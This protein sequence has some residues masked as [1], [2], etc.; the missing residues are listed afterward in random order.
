M[1]HILFFDHPE[2][3][4]QNLTGGKGVNLGRLSQA[5]FHVPPGFSVST[6]AYGEFVGQG[7][8]GRQI[9]ELLKTV[10]YDDPA[11]L[12]KQSAAIRDLLLSAPVPADIAEDIRAAYQMLG[13]GI[14]VAVRSSGTA[15]DL[16][17]ASFAG[18]HDTYLD[19]RGGDEV[20]D[21]VRR[22]WASLWTARAIDYRHHN[23]FEHNAVRIAV[24]VQKMVRSDVAGVMFTANPLTTATDETVIN[25]T[26]GLGES[27]VQG[28]VTPDQYVVQMP[29]NTLIEQMPG[30]KEK[31]MVRDQATGSG[32]LT[33][34]VPEGERARFCLD[35]SQLAEL[36]RL[37]EKVQTYYGGF[38]QD[39]EWAIEDGV[40]Y[41]LQSRPITGVEFS[42]DADVDAAHTQGVAADAVWTRAF[43]DA[44]ASGVVSPLT[45]STR[46]PLFSDRNLRYIW[47]NF[48]CQDLA[49][50]RA[51]KYWK[52]ELYYN[53]EFERRFVERMVPPPLRPMLLDF[54]PPLQHQEMI[55]APFDEAQ[56]LRIIMRWHMLDNQSTPTMATKTFEQWRRRTDYEGLSYAQLRELDDEAVIAYCQRMTEIFGEWND[57]M[58]V[59]IPIT[60]RLLMSGLKWMLS[61]WYDGG[62][63]QTAF[64]KL[65]AG[66]VRRTD[67]QL[68]ND[69]LLALVNIIRRS[70]HLKDALDRHEGEAFF[71]DIADLQEGRDFLRRYDQWIAKW[72]HRG[73]ADRDYMYPRR[74]EDPA[75]DV[76][77]FKVMMNADE[78]HDAEAAEREISH[79]RQAMLDDV[80]ANL[81]LKSGGAKKA[82][83]FKF[84]FELTHEYLVMRDNERARPTDLLTYARKRG[85]VE[86]GRRLYERGQIDE[87]RDFHFLSELEL[88]QHF[89]GRTENR[90]LL[91]TKIR[92]RARDC[93]RMLRKQ[94]SMPM[95]MKRNRPIDLEHP[96]QDGADGVFTGTPTSPGVITGTARVVMDHSEMGRVQRGEILVTHSTDPGW[97]PVFGLISA[98]VIETGGLLSHASCL[99]REYGF[100]AVHL[101]HAA[102]LIPDGARITVDGDTG[103]I[104][105]V[106]L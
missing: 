44:L 56:F 86:I 85:Y 30:A 104:I 67:T 53:V 42:W 26:W 80:L 57:L 21:A 49:D 52:G 87:A 83:I 91:K 89:R 36:A 71:D 8:I 41:L 51:F 15:E 94:V 76:R 28:I 68:E 102:K 100:P 11:A 78:Y 64:A 19:V 33:E 23:G 101:P 59:P 93:D 10:S 35:S 37:G 84:V 106:E 1:S 40:L 63:A 82:E 55:D 16:A 46:F 27:L 50:M 105:L 90:D 48:G 60:L 7:D 103:T 38:P 13:D 62:D 25:A 96:P 5:G 74:A 45:Y 66:A 34:S 58:W 4:A 54:I 14:H 32:V 95:H 12:E 73:H 39:I 17:D 9:D 72:G 65:V 79:Q 61:N 24:V 47:E 70:P 88:F 81:N 2:A 3:L 29:G 18:Q 20:V 97:N 43:G 22:C 6:E 92:A 98:V 75:I 69:D 99:A 31:R 77:A